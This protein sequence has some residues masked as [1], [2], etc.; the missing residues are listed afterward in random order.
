MA[1]TFALAT[2]N[3]GEGCEGLLDPSLCPFPE[4]LLRKC[5]G[6]RKQ[7]RT[8]VSSGFNFISEIA[9]EQMAGV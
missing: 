6:E 4:T 3:E 2:I 9:K 7:L 8:S 1:F 5:Q